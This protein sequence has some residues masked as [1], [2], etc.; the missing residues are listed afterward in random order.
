MTREPLGGTP[1][2]TADRVAAAWRERLEID[3][4]ITLE[5]KAAWVR[6]TP[7]ARLTEEELE[8]EKHLH[9]VTIVGEVE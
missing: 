8:L 6:C 5:E 3:R 9:E 4:P 1:E 7:K 2:E